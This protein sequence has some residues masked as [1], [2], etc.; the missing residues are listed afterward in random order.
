VLACDCG[1]DLWFYRGQSPHAVGPIGHEFVGVVDQVGSEVRTLAEGDLVIAPFTFCDG[2]CA[3]CRAGWLS[4][5]LNGGAF[6]NQDIDGGQGEAVR[7]PFADATLVSVPGSAPEF[8]DTTL[9][10]LPTLSDVMAPVTTSRSRGSNPSLVRS[11]FRTTSRSLWTL[12]TSATSA[13][14][15]DVLEGRI[16]PGMAFE[17]E[18]GLEGIV[19]ACDAMDQRRAIKSL[20]RVA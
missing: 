3:N 10:S 8:S 6:G 2:T 1:T 7:S 9:R 5:C 18:T 4:N 12:S 13:C 17:F 16:N 15:A 11:E 20:V 14:V 19:E